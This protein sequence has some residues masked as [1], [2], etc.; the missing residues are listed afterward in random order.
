MEKP[1]SCNFTPEELATTKERVAEGLEKLW[2]SLR[3]D[4]AKRAA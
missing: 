1:A 3:V 2:R 4:A